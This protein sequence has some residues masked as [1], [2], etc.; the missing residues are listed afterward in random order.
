MEAAW[1]LSG[2]RLCVHGCSVPTICS[3]AQTTL[4]RGAGEPASEPGDDRN[5]GPHSASQPRVW[6]TSGASRLCPHR[7]FSPGPQKPPQALSDHGLPPSCHL[8]SPSQGGA[9]APSQEAASQ[10]S[11]R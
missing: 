11:T 8:A 7:P 3:S 4:P 2:L 5:A 1:A 6:R 10:L 9:W